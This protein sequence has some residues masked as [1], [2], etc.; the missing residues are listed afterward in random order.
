MN[1]TPSATGVRVHNKGDRCHRESSNGNCAYCNA[2]NSTAKGVLEPKLP[3]SQHTIN[4]GVEQGMGRA[5][6]TAARQTYLSDDLLLASGTAALGHRADPLS[7]DIRLE[8]AQ[9][10]VQLGA[11][12][13]WH[14]GQLSGLSGLGLGW[15]LVGLG[16]AGLVAA[17][18]CSL[19]RLG[20][21]DREHK[22]E[23]I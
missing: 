18:D 11:P 17:P 6:A 5:R 12:G 22:R 15:H 2:H 3:N 20:H 23:F 10:G 8:V 14:V 16:I 19:G 4:P 13:R 7:A 1:K 9:H 21:L